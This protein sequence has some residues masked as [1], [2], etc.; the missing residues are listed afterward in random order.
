MGEVG[1]LDLDVAFTQSY[2][3]KY[4][5]VEIK[6]NLDCVKHYCRLPG[7]YPGRTGLRLGEGDGGQEE[8]VAK[9]S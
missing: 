7:R 4:K 5:V 6:I 9:M 2:A 1:W 8:T 3:E